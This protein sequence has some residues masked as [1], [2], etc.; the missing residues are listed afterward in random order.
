MINSHIRC[1]SGCEMQSEHEQLCVM[2]NGIHKQ[3]A[4]CSDSPRL[5]CILPAA[6]CITALLHPSLTFTN[7][8]WWICHV[9]IS[10]PSVLQAANRYI[11]APTLYNHPSLPS[12]FSVLVRIRSTPERG[13]CLHYRS[14]VI[15]SSCS[16]SVYQHQACVDDAGVNQVLCQEA[17]QSA[18]DP[19]GVNIDLLSCSV[20]PP[21]TDTYNLYIGQQ[22]VAGFL[23]YPWLPAIGS[24]NVITVYDNSIIIMIII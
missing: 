12:S 7:L 20:L 19:Q 17:S 23:S 9:N 1:S 5:A 14:Q 6:Q 3:G 22:M 10:D 4:H 18:H 8:L 11:P 16:V 24:C 13:Y 21:P 15:A 2:I